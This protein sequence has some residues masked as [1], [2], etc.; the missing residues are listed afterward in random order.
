MCV[1]RRRNSPGDLRRTPAGIERSRTV[2]A[3]VASLVLSGRLLE[4]SRP[5]RSAART[6]QTVDATAN[7]QVIATMRARLMHEDPECP[8]QRALAPRRNGYRRM[9]WD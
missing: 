8:E 4:H 2:V 3:R 1:R 9:S 7:S 6:V 5:S